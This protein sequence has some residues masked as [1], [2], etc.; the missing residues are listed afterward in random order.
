MAQAVTRYLPIC[1]YIVSRLPYF[2]WLMVVITLSAIAVQLVELQANFNEGMSRID[3]TYFWV[4]DFLFVFFT[5]IELTLKV[6]AFFSLGRVREREK[7]CVVMCWNQ[8]FEV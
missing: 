8:D 3:P 6:L 1:S 5:L 2:A 7:R 4:A